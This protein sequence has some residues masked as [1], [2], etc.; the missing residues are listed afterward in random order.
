VSV[1]RSWKAQQAAERLQW[2]PAWQDTGHI[3]TRD[4]GEPRHP[5]RVRVLFG[6]A[7]KAAGVPHIR[8]HDPRHGW[9]TLALRAGVHPKVV[10]ERLGH[11][12]IGITLNTY[13]HVLPDM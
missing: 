3:F 2:K 8:L 12:D 6:Q 11:A 13:S 4:N 5:D 10:Q 7:V 9:A 1:L